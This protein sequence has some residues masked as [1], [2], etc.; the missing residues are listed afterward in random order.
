MG[1]QESRA[2][3]SQSGRME[4]PVMSRMISFL[5]ISS[6]SPLCSFETVS[7]FPIITE[8]AKEADPFFL[9]DPFRYLK[10]TLSS[11]RNLLQAEQPQ[12]SACPHRRGVPSF[13]SFLWSSSGCTL[14]GPCLS[15]TEDSTSGRSTPGE[16][17][18]EQ[19]RG[20]HSPP[21]T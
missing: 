21:T 7:L 18:P 4:Q 3:P 1:R 14:T 8:P 19:N 12:F 5:Y 15:C 20:A 10:S 11:P 13:G 9:I 16:V 6:K 2:H 17:S